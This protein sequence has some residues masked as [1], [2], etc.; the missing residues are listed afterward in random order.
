ML[1]IKK[2]LLPV[3]FPNTSLR[4]IHQAAT[5]AH[6]FHSEIVILHAVTAE[7]HAAGVPVDGA[8]F[9]HWDM[10]AEITREAEKQLDG[11]LQPE[12]EGLAIRCVILRG[13]P[14]QAI[15]QTARVEEANMIM[16]PS[17][18]AVFN[19]FLLGSVTAKILQG[20]ECP[21]WTD[22]YVEKSE[23]PLTA[24]NP[25][26][27][28]G[29]V[30]M[31]RTDDMRTL[32]HEERR[33]PVPNFA[34]HNVLCAVDWG[35]RSDKAVSWAAPI[36][37]EFGARL[38]LAHVTASVEFWGPGGNYVDPK[39]K[40]A[41][42]SG[43]SQRLTKLKQDMGISADTLI[44]SGDVPK[45]LS[46]AAKQTKADLLVTGC[47]PYDGNLRIHGY[48]VICAVPVPVLSV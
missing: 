40:E 21:V 31:N 28:Y 18:G 1:S 22:G 48:A 14:A 25:M 13:N 35:P 11:S 8:A 16:M 41:L 4:I 6:H 33:G 47:Y 42:V 2:I 39:W 19:Q 34:I 36:A 45:V 20:S 3:D 26:L 12:L 24:D 5:L 7:S 46:Q 38:T 17:G 27:L 43:A 15:V 32:R 10:L 23:D 29:G 9:S 44:G 30:G 37:A